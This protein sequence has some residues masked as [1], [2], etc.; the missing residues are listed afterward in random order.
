MKLILC[1]E[2]FHTPNT[3]EACVK[4]CGKP[5]DQISVAIINEAH[6]REVVDKHWL[7]YNLRCVADNFP[8]HLDIVNLLALELDEIEERIQACDVIFVAGGSS[9]YLKTVFDKTGFTTLLPKLL[10][11]KVYVGSSAG[12]MVMGRRISSEAYVKLFGERDD[13]DNKEFLNLVDFAVVPHLD[14]EEMPQRPEVIK[15]VSKTV[16]FPVYGLRDDSA[17]VVDGD[18]V[19]FIGSEPLKVN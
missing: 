8:G 18:K 1:S 10:E 2:G 11:T 6:N 14:S 16:D 13:Y 15:E 4:L 7:V 17:V 19:E 5:K 12:S 9:D 3:I